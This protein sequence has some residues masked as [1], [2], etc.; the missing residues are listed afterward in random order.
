MLYRVTVYLL[1]VRIWKSEDGITLTNLETGGGVR[2]VSGAVLVD[3]PSI[4]NAIYWE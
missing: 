3:N 2:A 1:L 4:A